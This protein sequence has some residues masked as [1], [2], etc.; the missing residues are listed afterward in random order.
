MHFHSLYVVIDN[1]KYICYV[2]APTLSFVYLVT[3]F[4]NPDSLESLSQN[5]QVQLFSQPFC[6]SRPNECAMTGDKILCKYFKYYDM[7]YYRYYLI[8]QWDRCILYTLQTSWM[9]WLA[10]YLGSKDISDEKIWEKWLETLEIVLAIMN[11]ITLYTIKRLVV[12]KMWL[13]FIFSTILAVSK[14][15]AVVANKLQIVLR[16]T[17]NVF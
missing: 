13:Y 16:T 15:W 5:F 1:I 9:K 2:I 6:E 8:A 11:S 7:V 3:K 17:N 12:S 10:L 4:I 14:P